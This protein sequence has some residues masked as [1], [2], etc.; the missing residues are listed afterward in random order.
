MKPALR[1]L[2]HRM[3]YAEYGGAPLLG[4]NGISIVCHGSSK[5]DAIRNA[6]RV[7]IECHEK[8]FVQEIKNRLESEK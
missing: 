5:A 6:V 8:Q 7:A 1:G 4:V 3:D 2:K